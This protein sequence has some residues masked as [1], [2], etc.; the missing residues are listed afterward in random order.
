MSIKTIIILLATL[1]FVAA[2]SQTEPTPTE[3][4]ELSITETAVP[5]NLPPT[6]ETNSVEVT[7]YNLGDGTI[8]Q[9]H[10]PEDSRFRNMPV[11]LE[12]VIG[13][14]E[15]E[16]PFP[17]ILIMH[18]SH[19]ICEDETIWPCP[20]EDE[21]AN[22]KGFTY[23]VEN[24]A[25]A[26]YASLSINV[27]AEHIFSHGEAPPTIRTKQ[28]IDMHLQ[29]LAAAN[30]GESDKFGI[31]LNGRVD[32][33]RMT[34]IGHSRGA[35]F[36]NWIIRD[37][38][39]DQTASD[40]GYGPVQGL[41][42][43]A[44]PIVATDTLPVVDLPI[45]LILPACDGDVFTMDGQKAYEAARFDTERAHLFTSV[46]LEHANHNNFNTILNADQP[47]PERPD[48]VE[49]V[50]LTP[51]AQRDFLTQYTID[52]L[53]S[54]YGPTNNMQTINQTLG[55]DP[56]FLVPT[57]LYGLS[58][59]VSTLYPAANR[60]TL[61]QP[62]GE[63][64]LSQDL[65][66]GETTFTDVTALFCPDGYYVPLHEPEKSESCRRVAFNQ[67]AYPQQMLI[68]WETS[69]A[70][71]R[72][73]VPETHKDLTTYTA[74]QLRAALDPLSP[75]NQP[76]DPQ[77]FTI[78]FVDSTGS[79]EQVVVPSIPFPIGETKPNDF[80]EGDYF[81]GNV[82]MS[83]LRIPLAALT[84]VDLAHI[85]EIALV[86]DQT[87]TGALFLADLELIK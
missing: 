87:P 44:P 23:L 73:T 8:I 17:V 84:A 59:Q 36:A 14:P 71:W 28:L 66:G 52:F 50:A 64:E 83:S 10:F 1:I 78:E 26:G 57:E 20:E 19:F 9:D 43:L 22:Y 21:Q 42:L 6:P 76:D 69:G 53:N 31:D 51:E 4:P 11:R 47:I 40:I 85:T 45:A 67:P 56:A 60:L 86:F 5:T 41:I 46:Y 16:G 79:R 77:S 29:E 24:L 32:L 68:N 65:L 37:L 38:M 62:Q 34:W 27:N 72:T 70:E 48:C 33:T 25:E 30:G 39:L 49:D 35:D 54:L 75:L 74:I 63:A 82:H 61:M 2:C 13:V 15:G 12:G 7:H 80:F 58:V 55:L 3:T 81:T 18:G